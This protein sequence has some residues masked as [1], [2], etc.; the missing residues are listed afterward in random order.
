MAEICSKC[1]DMCCDMASDIRF[2]PRFFPHE[3]KRGLHLKF[4]YK[5]YIIDGVEIIVM[6]PDADCPYFRDGRCMLYG[7]EDMPLDCR[8][9]PAAP[10]LDG[11]VIVE[12]DGCPMAKHFDTPEYREKVLKLLKPY[13]P[14]D[15]RWLEAYWRLDMYG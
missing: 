1:P 14:L 6:D 10:T 8:I 7:M 9:F 5:V 3:V 12:Y 4:N 11:S 13:M 15:K 2:E